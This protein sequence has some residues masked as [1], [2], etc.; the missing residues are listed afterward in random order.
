MPGGFLFVA[1]CSHNVGAAEFADAVRHGLA[2]AGRGARI[3][4][5]AGASPDH[6]VHPAL[7]ESSYLKAL[8]LIL[9]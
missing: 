3:L 7:P 9:N 8:T 5:N 2:D 1:S 4:R 6:P